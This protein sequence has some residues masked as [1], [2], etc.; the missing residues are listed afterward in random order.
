MMESYKDPQAVTPAKAGVYND[1]KALDPR[2]RGDDETAH[3]ET[4]YDTIKLDRQANF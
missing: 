4:F 3:S 1:L 2:L